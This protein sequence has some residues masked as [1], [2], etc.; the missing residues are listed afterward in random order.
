MVETS[1]ETTVEKFLDYNYFL[2]ILHSTLTDV[3]KGKKICQYNNSPGSTSTSKI[4]ISKYWR[5]SI[6]DNWVSDQKAGFK[7]WRYVRYIDFFQLDSQKVGM[8]DTM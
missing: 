8:K 6:S 7:K 1:L 4:L 3:G 2:C 5:E